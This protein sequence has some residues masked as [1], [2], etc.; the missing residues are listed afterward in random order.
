MNDQKMDKHDQVLVGLVMSL[1]A[2]AMQHLG[3]ITS[4][5]TGKV[6][7]DLEQARG[8]ID[9]LEML[10]VKCRQETPSEI[11]HLLDNAVMGLQ[12][13]YLDE[14]RKD[15]TTARTSP[16]SEQGNTGG[17][18]ASEQ[19]TGAGEGDTGEGDTG[20]A[21]A[22]DQETGAG[23]GGTDAPDSAEERTASGEAGAAETVEGAPD[24]EGAG[25]KET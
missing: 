14:M 3:K 4:P 6:E 10:K 25:D 7:R 9:I 24:T 13:N 16:G 22:S 1:Q 2:A 20:E 15:R 23:E 8:T 18:A 17:A 19:E 11:L 12:M 5:L 21:A